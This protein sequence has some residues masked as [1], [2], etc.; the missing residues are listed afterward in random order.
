MNVF[1]INQ[2]LNQTRMYTVF[3]SRERFNDYFLRCDQTF[4]FRT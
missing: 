1:A 3:N 2:Y 4:E